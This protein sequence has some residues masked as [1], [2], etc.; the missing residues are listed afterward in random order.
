MKR[1][2]LIRKSIILLT[3]FVALSAFNG[4]SATFATGATITMSPSTVYY[5]PG[6]YSN[7]GSTL[8]QAVDSSATS[9]LI[10]DGW[11]LGEGWTVKVDNEFMHIEQLI[12]AYPSYTMVVTRGVNGSAAASH[13][14]GKP[15]KTQ[16]ATVNIYAN[17][18]TSPGLGGFQIY[19][20]LPPNVQYGSLSWDSQW[21]SSTGRSTSSCDGPSL[22]NGI[23]RVTCATWGATPSG[24]TG[25]GRIGTLTIAP[26]PEFGAGGAID[27]SQSQLTDITG[28]PIPAVVSNLTVLSL[29]CPDVNLDTYIDNGDQF[30]V[31]VNFNDTGVDSGATLVGQVNPSQTTIS[32]SDQSKL[33]VGNTISIDAEQMSVVAL[34][35]GSPDTMTVTRALNWSTAA[36]HSAGRPIFKATGDGN[37]DGKRGYT[38]T[39]DLNNDLYVDSFDYLLVTGAVINRLSCPQ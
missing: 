28:A 25:S 5:I 33:A 14:S 34:H 7:S 17:G 22:I 27:F 35:D 37:H 31:A 38:D 18:I 13:L 19:M 6:T 26:P 15:I 30:D 9:M 10:S 16:T 2:A 32:I 8:S 36:S 21:L 39:R 11:K 24:P 20:I 1:V 3:S 12:P 4:P 29:E 23:W